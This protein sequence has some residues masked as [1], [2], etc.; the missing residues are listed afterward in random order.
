MGVGWRGWACCSARCS[1]ASWRP[2]PDFDTEGPYWDSSHLA[3]LNEAVA[4]WSTD[5]DYDPGVADGPYNIAVDGRVPSSTLHPGCLSS[6][7]LVLAITC[8]EVQARYDSE[9]GAYYRIVD[10]DIFFNMERSGA[11]NW[12]VGST[13]PPTATASTSVGS[14]RTSS[15]TPCG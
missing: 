3:R 1:W 12:W 6:W 8:K 10:N 4:E 11:P 7:G 5:T 14:S 9:I 15:G 2:D 13:M